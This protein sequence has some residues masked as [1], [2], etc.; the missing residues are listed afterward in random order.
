MRHPRLIM[1]GLSGNSL[2][3]T[4]GASL[5]FALGADP[6]GDKV[7]RDREAYYKDVK[8]KKLLGIDVAAGERAYVYIYV[9]RER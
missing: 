1:L 3:P 2:G 4:K 9:Y 6:G 8:E 7:I 5:I